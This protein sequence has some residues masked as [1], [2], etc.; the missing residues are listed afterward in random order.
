MKGIWVPCVA[1]ASLLRENLYRSIPL[2][3]GKQKILCLWVLVTSINSNVVLLFLYSVESQESQAS[4]LRMKED[5]RDS[6]P[7]LKNGQLEVCEAVCSCCSMLT[8]WLITESIFLFKETFFFF[9]FS[10]SHHDLKVPS[11]QITMFHFIDKFL[12]NAEQS[13]DTC[14]LS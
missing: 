14:F 8:V 3:L 6:G 11:S 13:S 7:R 12:T 2:V 10:S 4:K 9:H 5:L 1:E